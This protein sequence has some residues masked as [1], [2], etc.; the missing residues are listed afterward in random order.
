MEAL[1]E[2]A[3]RRLAETAVTTSIELTG[4]IHEGRIIFDPPAGAPILAE[5]NE[6]FIGGLRLVVKLREERD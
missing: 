2:A 1:A 5:G 3:R 6:L 4:T